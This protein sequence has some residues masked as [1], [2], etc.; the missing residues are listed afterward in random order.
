M[1]VIIVVIDGDVFGSVSV[2]VLGV[3]RSSRPAWPNGSDCSDIVILATTIAMGT[4]FLTP[5]QGD[6]DEDV[7]KIL[8][9]VP[10]ERQT[11]L[12]SATM[13]AWVKQLTKS[14]LKNPVMV[15]L[16]AE[17]GSVRLMLRIIQTQL[18]ENRREESLAATEAV[19]ED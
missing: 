9:T 11:M 17:Q 19:N 10:E 4:L 3:K 14:H 1:N 15:D 6:R 16:V 13:P 12:F 8:E 7:D 5:I 18:I 2:L